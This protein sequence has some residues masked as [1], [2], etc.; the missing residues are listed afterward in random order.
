M[1]L[2]YCTADIFV[3]EVRQDDKKKSCESQLAQIH[4]I[5]LVVKQQYF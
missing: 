4:A 5:C 1:Y 3:I 2:P